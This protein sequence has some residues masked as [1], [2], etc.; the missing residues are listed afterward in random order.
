MSSYD[1]FGNALRVAVDIQYVY[2]SFYKSFE[3]CKS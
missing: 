2:K 3:Y 1:G